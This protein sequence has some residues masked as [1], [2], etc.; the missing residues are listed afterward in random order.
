MIMDVSVIQIGNS[1]GIQLSKSILDRYSIKDT[2]ELILEKEQ[3]VIR[4]KAKS[5]KG[6]EAAFKKMHKLNE[7][8][9]LFPDVFED[10]NLEE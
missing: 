6:W 5:R 7:D 9:A 4:P 1:K 8:K 3:I 2:V 10:E